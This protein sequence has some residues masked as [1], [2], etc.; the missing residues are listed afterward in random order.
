MSVGLIILLSI[1]VIDIAQ[2]SAK[3]F[4]SGAILENNSD[5]AFSKINRYPKDR[6]N[7]RHPFKIKA[8]W[9]DS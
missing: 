5:L 8:G 2:I 1:R 3:P 6:S 9:Q 4:I 7:A